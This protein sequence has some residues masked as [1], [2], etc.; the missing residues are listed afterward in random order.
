MVVGIVFAALEEAFD[1]ISHSVPFQKLKKASGI[2]SNLF[3]WIRPTVID[4]DCS[5]LQA[6]EKSCLVCNKAPYSALLYS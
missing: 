4:R 6:C 3:S 1:S 5:W 2:T